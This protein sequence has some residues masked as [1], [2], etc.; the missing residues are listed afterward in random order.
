MT[1]D[2]IA[3]AAA[4]LAP[5][6]AVLLVAVAGAQIALAHTASLSPWSGGGFG[7]FSSTDTWARRHL[8]A[9]AIR[10][11]LRTELDVPE[12]LAEEERRALALPDGPQLRALA[13]RLAAIEREQ[14][15][16]DAA[17]LEA[18]ALQVW[19]VRY[20]AETLAPSGEMLAAVEIPAGDE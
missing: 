10:P 2:R 1:S 6:P 18:V 9:W 8:H 13:A 16:P 4:R 14:G 5:L 20:D 12:E 7:M 15:D 11:G 19:R 3:A 17:P